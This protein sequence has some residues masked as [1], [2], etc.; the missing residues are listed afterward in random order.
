MR[1]FLFGFAALY[2][3]LW[4]CLPTEAGSLDD[5]RLAQDFARFT[6]QM[7]QA[8]VPI[9][10]TIEAAR[11]AISDAPPSAFVQAMVP[12]IVSMAYRTP[13]G[14]TDREAAN[15]AI[16]FGETIFAACIQSSSTQ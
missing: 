10:D 9:H 16:R 13:L 4:V 6:M 11:D 15:E 12:S 7:R 8:G 1:R 3:S 2:I 14:Q 5:C